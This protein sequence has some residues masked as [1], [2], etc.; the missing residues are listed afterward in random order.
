[1]PYSQD[2]KINDFKSRRKTATI[3]GVNPQ[4]KTVTIK[5]TSQQGDF[6][7]LDLS[8]QNVGLSW[9]RLHMPQIGDRVIIDTTQGDYP[10]M[11]GMAPQ[12]NQLLPYLDPGEIADINSDGSFIHLRNARRRVQSTGELIGYNETKGPNG[13]TDIEM[14][15]GG[16]TIG[17]RSKQDTNSKAPRWY[18]HSYI[19]MYDNGD[20]NIQ[21]RQSGQTKG[22]LRMD[23]D[24]GFVFLSAG[25]GTVQEYVELDP[26]NKLITLFSDGDSHQHTQQDW[27]INVYG[28][29]L[30]NLGN[31]L[32]INVGVATS[33]IPANFND[34]KP[35]SDLSQGDIR[36]NNSTT[37][38]TGNFYLHIKGNVNIELDQGNYNLNVDQGTVNIT[39]EGD[40]NVSTQGNANVTS[41]G[42]AVILAQSEVDITGSKI[43]LNGGTETV[44]T[45]TDIQTHTHSGVQNGE[46]FTGTSS[47][48]A[49]RQVYA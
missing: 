23:G 43:T 19:A 31:I 48:S 5:Y 42:K 6:Q 10:I 49:T 35:D 41:Q 39:S 28:N 7:N 46:G 34:V 14:E 27:K 36:I 18:Q 11:V 45:I 16:I 8:F 21:S 22:L 47:Y 24:N 13:E 30:H 40:V 20:I 17:V 1:M 33:S 15:P 25:D 3:T 4:A 9:G 12:N 26:V 2:N 32:E 38:G 29:Q 37:A 44:A